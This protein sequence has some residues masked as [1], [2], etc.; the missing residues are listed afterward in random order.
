[1]FFT[2]ALALSWGMA[3]A[4]DT[5]QIFDFFHCQEAGS[6]PMPLT[7]WQ[8]ATGIAFT[9]FMLASIGVF[10]WS[11]HR[12]FR[13]VSSGDYFGQKVTVLIRRV[14]ICLICFWLSFMLIEGVLPYILTLGFPPEKRAVLEIAILDLEVMFLI[15]GITFYVISKILGEAHELVE[16]NRKFI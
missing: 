10:F 12:F 1:M 13:H 16:E 4:G 3:I 7:G 11:V 15:T 5:E 9:G 14:S 6:P 8:I 2:A